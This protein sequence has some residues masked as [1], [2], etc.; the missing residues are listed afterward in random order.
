MPYM[1]TCPYMELDGMRHRITEYPEVEGTHQDHQVQLLTR[2]W[3][4]RPSM[5]LCWSARHVGG[6]FGCPLPWGAWSLVV[7][8]R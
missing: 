1:G 6:M 5:V 3:G 8:G 4:V 2:C 7:L